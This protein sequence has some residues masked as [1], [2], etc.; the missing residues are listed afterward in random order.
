MMLLGML[1]LSLS[2]PV[3]DAANPAVAPINIVIVLADDLGY[4]DPGCYNDQSKIP[5]PN[6]DRLAAEGLRFTDAHTPSSV[7]SPT[8]YGLLTGRYAWRTKLK[9]SVLWPWSL[10]LIEQDRLTLPAMLQQHG[11]HTACIGKWHLG[12]DW[13]IDADGHVSDE[14]DGVAIAANKRVPLGKRVA[15]SRPIASGPTSRGFNYYFGDDVPNFPPRCF[16]ENDHTVGIPSVDKPKGMFGHDGP[17]LAGWDLSVVLPTLAQKAAAYIEQ[18]AKHPEQPF[19]LYVPLTAPHTPIAPSPHFTGKSEA[20]LYGDF[21]NEV[22]WVLGQVLS[23]L[24]RTGAAERTLVIFTSDNGSPQR[25]GV[26]MSGP[27]GSVKA[28]GHDPSRPWRGMKADAWEAGHRVPFIVRWPGRAPAGET[29]DEPI[30]L[31][32]LM[33]TFASLVGHPLPAD[34]AEDSFDILGALEGKRLH[35]PVHDHLVHHS[36]NGVF[37]IRRG[38]FKLILGKGSGGFTRFKPAADAPRGQL[39]NLDDD[40]GEMNNLYNDKPEV[41]EKLSELLK[42][43]RNSGNSHHLGASSR[44]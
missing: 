29:S 34:S 15:F 27:T 42:Q 22:D 40:P 20:G 18:R 37:A 12:W 21:V 44:D 32:D 19:F 30:I 23:A 1:L 43:V 2:Q 13:P 5:T 9:R 39:Y 25:N 14:F 31:T 4:G 38:P 3:D 28:F 35:H 26:G 8:R 10:P 7:C 6:I 17:T 33:R 16:I 41:V 36:G 11:Y 24:D